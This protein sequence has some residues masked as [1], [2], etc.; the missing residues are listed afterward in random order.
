MDDE[1]QQ[2]EPCDTTSDP[3]DLIRAAFKARHWET[4]RWQT[5]GNCEAVAMPV[6]KYGDLV[7][8]G[9]ERARTGERQASRFVIVTYDGEWYIGFYHN[10]RDW[11]DGE[12]ESLTVDGAL[13]AD[14]VV[15]IVL[16]HV[17]AWT[18]GVVEEFHVGD[19]VYCPLIV[20]RFPHFV[21]QEGARGTVTAT[22][23][24]D[25][26][27]KLDKKVDGCEEWNNELQWSAADEIARPFLI[28]PKLSTEGAQRLASIETSGGES[29]SE[30]AREWAIS[31]TGT[32][33]PFAEFVDH[34]LINPSRK[35]KLTNHGRIALDEHMRGARTEKT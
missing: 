31:G 30:V 21:V 12:G 16:D 3:L 11:N 4:Q 10:A 13:S 27:V 5:G 25:V 20:E 18:K 32:D 8:Y 17:Q 2:H 35:L 14:E 26:W 6:E 19:R 34:S 29:L 1:K 28:I 33:L 9:G 23:D 15:S 24:G 22:D 7:E